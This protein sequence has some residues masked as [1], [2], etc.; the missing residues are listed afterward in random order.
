MRLLK[1]S[2]VLSLLNSYVV[3]SPQPSNLSYNWNYGSMLAICLGIQII[4][5]VLVAMHYTPNIDLAF[6]SVEH[7]I[8]DVNYGWFL[9][10]LH[11]NGASAF[12]IAVYCHI[13]RG[14]Y[15]SSYKG[16]RTAPWTIG[17]IILIVMIGT[18]FLGYS[19]IISESY[20]TFHY[21]SNFY[22]V[23]TTYYICSLF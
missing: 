9:R 7:L 12:F 22:Y 23:N 16:P 18:A 21:L 19:L 15:Y 2:A 11:A 5:G 20:D 10:Y 6:I 4:T 1:R 8:R 17:V 3:D 13:G 14:L